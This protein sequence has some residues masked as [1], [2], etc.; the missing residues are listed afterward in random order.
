MLQTTVLALCVLSDCDQV[1]I[2]I[3]GLVSW[4]AEAWP[5]IGIQLEFLTECQVERP[6]TLAD[7]SGH[8]SLQPNPV[9]LC[10]KQYMSK[11]ANPSS[12]TCLDCK[13]TTHS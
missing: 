7:R 6:M 3:P 10:S 1:D 2:V 13:Q 5:H 4:N 11:A 9:F 12:A 8:G